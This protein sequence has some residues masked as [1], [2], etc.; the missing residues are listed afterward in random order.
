[1]SKLRLRPA[2]PDRAFL[3]SA[4]LV[5]EWQAPTNFSGRK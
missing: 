4:Q 3:L 1:V 2:Y 5:P